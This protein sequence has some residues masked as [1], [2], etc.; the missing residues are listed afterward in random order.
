MINEKENDNNNTTKDNNTPEDGA[1]IGNECKNARN[2]LS[3]VNYRQFTSSQLLILSEEK[4]QKIKVND[5][6]LRFSISLP[7]FYSCFDMVG[8][9]YRWFKIMPK[10]FIEV[11][12]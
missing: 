2:E 1:E 3:L 8:S 4:K 5:K 9:Y 12:S 7:D 11:K 6:I 10:K